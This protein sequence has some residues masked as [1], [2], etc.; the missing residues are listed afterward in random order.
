MGEDMVA[1]DAV[2]VSELAQRRSATLVAY[3]L[4]DNDRHR[5]AARCVL[6]RSDA[7]QRELAPNLNESGLLG[8]EIL[9]RPNAERYPPSLPIGDLN[10][11]VGEGAVS[12]L[13]FVEFDLG[14]IRWRRFRS[15]HVRT[16][17]G[18]LS[19]RHPGLRAYDLLFRALSRPLGGPF[20]GLVDH[21]FSEPETGVFPGNLE[22][23][24]GVRPYFLGRRQALVRLP[25][26]VWRHPRR[27][28]ALSKNPIPHFLR[29]E[30]LG[31]LDGSVIGLA[32]Q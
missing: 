15:I 23:M 25:H 2:V 11:T 18:L 12:E 1:G 28:A 24:V 4:I 19:L 3:S 17:R 9:E 27:H 16:V 26:G 8:M 21:C 22:V 10:R 7:A 5:P 31:V 32:R 6:T 30:R 13:L 20:R 14:R 29:R